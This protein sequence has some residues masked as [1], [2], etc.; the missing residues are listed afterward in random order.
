MSVRPRLVLFL[1]LMCLALSPLAAQTRPVA[2]PPVIRDYPVLT[3][4]RL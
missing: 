2:E 3:A 1:G 4:N